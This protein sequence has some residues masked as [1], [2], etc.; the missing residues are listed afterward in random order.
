MVAPNIISPT[1]IN[2][3]TAV[4]AI[5]TSPTAIV[6]NGSGSNKVLKIDQLL[7]T[8]VNGTANA[9]VTVDL[10]RSSTAYDIAY[11][12]T[13]PAGATLDIISSR[14]YLEEGDTLRLTASINSYLDGV[15]SYEDIS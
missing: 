4:L 14:I 3:K 15:C 1:T 11:L 2:G 6:T 13:V 10:F 5:T 9:T 7:I 8:N 12:M